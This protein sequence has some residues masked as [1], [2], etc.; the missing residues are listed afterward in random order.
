MKGTNLLHGSLDFV[1]GAAKNIRPFGGEETT[2][3]RYTNT[4]PDVDIW[5]GKE[6]GQ[7]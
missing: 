4:A 6:A 1:D 5:F 3:R 2:G 7:R